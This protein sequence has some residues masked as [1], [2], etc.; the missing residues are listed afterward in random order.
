MFSLANWL[1]SGNSAPCESPGIAA[2]S[3]DFAMSRSIRI[4][5]SASMAGI[6]I[7]TTGVAEGVVG[8]MIVHAVGAF[9]VGAVGAGPDVMGREGS[10]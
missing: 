5:S 10:S 7:G 3:G 4:S 1:P 6:S 2:I 9:A 8:C